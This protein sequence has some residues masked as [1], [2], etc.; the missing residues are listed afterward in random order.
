MSRTKKF[1]FN[2]IA[3]TIFQ[4]ITVIA[5]F[6]VPRIILTFYGSEINGLVSS[7]TQFIAYFNLV[8]AGIAGASIYALYK[9]LADGDISK[10]NAVLSATKRFYVLAGYIFSLL[11]IGLS[12]IYPVFIKSSK[13]STFGTGILV[14]ILGAAGA[15]EFFTMAKYR[16][17]LTADQKQYVISFASIISIILNTVIISLMA[18]IGSSIV[19][20]RLVALLSVFIRSVLL[21]IY[22][23]RKYSNIDYKSIPDKKAL[24]KRWD[25]FYLQILGVV[26]TGSPI[27]IAT[28]FTSL[29]MVSV[30]SIFNM[31]IAGISGLVGIFV[32]GLSA[33]FGDVIVRGEKR[34]LQ[35]AYQEF[36]F[37]YYALISWIFSCTAVLIMP[38]I[39]L[40]TKGITD[41][42]YNVPLI[43]ILI[44]VNG[45][46]S[47]LKTPQGMLIISAGFYRET[48]IQVTIQAMLTIVCGV[49]LVQKWGVAGILVGSIISNVYRVIDLLIY[50]PRKITKLKI[51][52]SLTRIFRVLFTFSVIFLPFYLTNIIVC[53]SVLDWIGWAI[54]VAIFAAL[55]VVF[56]NLLFDI[57]EI[58]NIANRLI[59]VARM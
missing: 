6:I 51:K 55:V 56:T 18:Y 37:A 21:S 3:A 12:I 13:I 10:I 30:F 38:F 36:E 42:N 1:I 34:I 39:N 58:K 17:L 27:L 23:K 15:L 19:V 7:I 29:K 9:P 46:L 54:L 45:L 49:F 26:Q 43:G 20:L 24:H 2:S 4:L 48:R 22:V 8:E 41:I 52:C 16:A 40:Y 25:A 57:K 14:L 33:S 11:I 44:T 53:E 35:K 28:I 50:V 59:N 47:H 5:G 31:V 32:S